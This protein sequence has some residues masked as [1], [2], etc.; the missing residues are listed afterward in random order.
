MYCLVDGVLHAH[1]GHIHDV[2][3]YPHTIYVIEC[4]Y[5]LIVFVNEQGNLSKTT[6]VPISY[7]GRRLK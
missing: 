6:H 3:F 2:L 1:I 5:I 4:I 7:R